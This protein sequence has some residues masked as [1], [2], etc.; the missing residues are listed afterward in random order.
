MA[1]PSGCTRKDQGSAGSEHSHSSFNVPLTLVPLAS[2]VQRAAPTGALSIT[3]G[4]IPQRGLA[5]V[6]VENQGNDSNVWVTA[7]VVSENR[8][9]DWYLSGSQPVGPIVDARIPGH[10]ERTMDLPVG[11]DCQPD[12][13]LVRVRLFTFAES[14]AANAPV[15]DVLVDAC[16]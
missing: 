15:D 5:R 14:V 6:A 8:R 3:S 1:C 11:V 16:R 7:E 13:A 4:G 2:H 12:T 9:Y 10:S